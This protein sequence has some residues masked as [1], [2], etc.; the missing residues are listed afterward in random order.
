MISGDHHKICVETGRRLGLGSHILQSERLRHTSGPALSQL[1]QESDGFSEVF[2]EDKYNI[3]A[4]LQATG[5]NCGMTGDGVNDAAAL[6]KANVG[7]AVKGATPAAQ[8]AADVVLLSEGLS[9]IITAIMR[10]RKIFQRVKNY[11]IYR[12]NISLTL[13]FFFAT[14]IVIFDESLPAIIIVLMALLNDFT[15]MTISTDKVVPSEKPDG[16][17]IWEMIIISVAMSLVSTIL[18]VLSYLS[19]RD[20][21]IVD[22]DGA[23]LD[24]LVYMQIALMNQITVFVART[25]GN[26]FSRRPGTALLTAI[27]AQMVITTIISLVW[28]F[29][30]GLSG[31]PITAALLVWLYTI[32]A[33]LIHDGVK[34][35]IYQAFKKPTEDMMIV[36][37]QSAARGRSNNLEANTFTSVSVEGNR[38]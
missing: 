13:L 8:S 11:C 25:H 32:V 5:I 34:L 10:S 14:M 36:D 2:P 35:S 18:S 9:V 31:V 21:W 16:W 23:Q 17:H 27:L 6:K 20:G 24:T 12:I 37:L 22:V 26:M 4:A 3:V 1:V 30:S 15:I 33:A 7:F 29:G 19:F 28:P 38:V